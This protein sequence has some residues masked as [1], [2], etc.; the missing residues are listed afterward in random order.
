MI[1]K[2]RAKSILSSLRSKG[3]DP[4]GISYNMNIYRGCQHQCIYCD[5]RSNCYQIDNFADILIKENAIDLL[6]Q[7][8]PAKRKKTTIGTGSMNDPYMP[9]EEELGLTR[10]ALQ[11]IYRYQF[12]VHIITKSNMVVRDLDI[13]RNI[14]K[15]YAAVS[16]TITSN[17]DELSRKIEPGAPVPSE[18]FEAMKVLASAGIY[19]G[20]IIS[21]VLPWVTDS[22]EN[23]TELL[24]HA[25]QV[26]AKYALMW[27]G[28]TQR[29][30]QREWFYDQLDKHFPGLK[31]K[32]IDRFGNTYECDSPKSEAINKAYYQV[33]SKL[34]LATQMKFYE[35]VDPQMVLF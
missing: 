11:L 30:G 2:I 33:C 8:L 6:K 28:L 27:P 31:E 10:Q 17:D 24:Q 14:S 22:I 32:Y 18:R 16:F 25:H 12:P 23:I 29:H 34:R 35:P 9:I 15:I 21:P 7:E 26:G 4:F 19:T 20:I 5:S 3:F 13:L 1:K